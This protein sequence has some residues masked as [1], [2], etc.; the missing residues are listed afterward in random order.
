MQASPCLMYFCSEQ[1]N[2]GLALLGSNNGC[3]FSS[4][5]VGKKHNEK[6]TYIATETNPKPYSNWQEFARYQMN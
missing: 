6:F 1:C 4:K 2:T 5:Q 3:H